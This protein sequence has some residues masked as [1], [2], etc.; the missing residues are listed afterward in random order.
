MESAMRAKDSVKVTTLRGLLS[1]FVNE[2]V[3]KKRK[4][5]EE[6]S[7]DEVLEV[8][9]RGV[10]QRKDAVEIF[11]KGGREDLAQNEEVEVKILNEFLPAQMSQEEI[12]KI[13]EV[14]KAEL[15]IT[16]KSKMG[17]LIGAIAKDMKGKADG[18]TIKRVVE[19]I[20]E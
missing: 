4:P 11:H 8:I 17:M 18:A 1:A 7:D 9:R 15:G 10:K 20:L 16:D 2:S 5:D 6:L 3:A 19:S 12:L 13:A 14:K